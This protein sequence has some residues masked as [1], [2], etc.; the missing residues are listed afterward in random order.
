MWND[1][2]S[3][4]G[5]RWAKPH[6]NPRV[7][8]GCGYHGKLKILAAGKGDYVGESAFSRW[9]FQIFVII[10]PKIGEDEPI[11]GLIR[12]FFFVIEV[13]VILVPFHVFFLIKMFS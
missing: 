9:W 10:T 5:N 12:M 13:W 7:G 3:K 11:V 2:S 6:R 8:G 4:N 1:I